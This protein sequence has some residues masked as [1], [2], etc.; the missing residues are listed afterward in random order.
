MS[1]NDE[2][3]NKLPLTAQL[4]TRIELQGAEVKRNERFGES[5]FHNEPN[6]ELSSFYK[7]VSKMIK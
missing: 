6:Y 4:S 3:N 1:K 2:L 5:K 7:P